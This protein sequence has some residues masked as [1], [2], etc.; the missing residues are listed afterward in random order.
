MYMCAVLSR[1][2]QARAALVLGPAGSSAGNCNLKSGPCTNCLPPRRG[3]GSNLHAH[4]HI[5]YGPCQGRRVTAH[6]AIAARVTV[7]SPAER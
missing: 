5:S 1:P 3:P 2:S 7:T 4:D 6:W